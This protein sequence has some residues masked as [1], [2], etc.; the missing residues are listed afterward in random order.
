MALTLDSFVAMIRTSRRTLLV[1]LCL[2]GVLAFPGRAQQGEAKRDPQLDLQLWV[3]DQFP[4]VLNEFLPLEKDAEVSFRTYR[5][6]YTNVLE[7]SCSITRKKDQIEAVVRL[8]NPTSL[9][10]QILAERK[11]N[12]HVGIKSIKRKLTIKE[13]RFTSNT[14]PAL[15][16]SLSALEKLELPVMTERERASAAKGVV[17]VTL[18]PTIY[19]FQVSISGGDAKLELDN[20]DHPLVRWA[21][22]TRGALARCQK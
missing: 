6:L 13:Y 9:Y 18:H 21:D 1:S 2:L 16:T 4:S 14:C 22:A 17:E 11:R 19:T 20:H 5:D 7:Y 12:P 10:D 15:E 8:A 3:E